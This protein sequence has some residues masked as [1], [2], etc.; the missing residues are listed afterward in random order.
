MPG[1]SKGS[2]TCWIGHLKQGDQWAAQHL[3]E[4]YF[5]RLVALA[6]AKLGQAPRLAAD[7]EDAALS[8][9]HILCDGA[10]RGRFDRLGDR[11]DLWRLLAVITSNKATDLKKWQGRAKRGGARVVGE[12]EMAGGNAGEP[13]ALELIVG[14]EPTP[15]FAAELAEEYQRRLDQLGDESLRRVAQLRLEG[16]DYDQIAGR[17]GVARR[18][19][20]RKLA[21]IRDAW[22]GAAGE[23]GAA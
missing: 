6:R 7:E 22:G 20:A 9:F 8:A 5:H 18:T 23:G 10:A 16:Y 14:N 17:L 2:V 13:A 12:G 11:D 3:W 4:R 1:A 15:E 21:M 19:V